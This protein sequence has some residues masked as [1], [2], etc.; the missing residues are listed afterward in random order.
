MKLNRWFDG[1]KFSCT[2]CGNCCRGKTKVYV[3][4]SELTEIADFLNEDDEVLTQ[5]YTY[6]IKDSKN[7][8]NRSLLSLKSKLNSDSTGLQ[9]VFLDDVTNKCKIYEVRPTQCRTYPFWPQNLIGATEWLAEAKKCEGISNSYQSSSGISQLSDLGTDYIP[10]KTVLENLVINE[11]YD[12]GFGPSW[13][14]EESKIALA[15]SEEVNPLIDDFEQEFFSTHSSKLLHETNSVQVVEVTTPHPDN[16]SSSDDDVTYSG[17]LNLT[18]RRLEFK[19]SLHMT[20]TECRLKPDGSVDPLYLALP[21]HSV[22][23]AVVRR[24]LNPLLMVGNGTLSASTA[25]IAS[26][27]HQRY[28]VCVIGAGGCALPNYLY[29]YYEPYFYQN[30]TFLIL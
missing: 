29:H 15:A 25:Q 17:E 20:Q 2:A 24:H 11:V 12:K 18:S 6:E 7:S 30:M 19:S 16:D 10:S 3:N 1:L 9:C 8:Q 4:E 14:Y 13:T 26:T 5:K 22:I 28:R 21:V 27:I 23:A